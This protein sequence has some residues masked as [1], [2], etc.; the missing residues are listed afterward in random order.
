MQSGADERG[1]E[2]PDAEADADAG[3]D[4]PRT[5]HRGGGAAG[6]ARAAARR[7]A[8]MCIVTRERDPAR[9]LIRFVADPDGRVVPDLAGKLPGRGAHVTASAALVRRAVDRHMFRRALKA[10]VTE[11]R[12]LDDET[13][14]LMRDQLV[15]TLPLLR[16]G[17]ALTVGAGKVEDAVRAGRVILVLHAAEAAED[18]VRKIAQAR[19]ATRHAHG[20]DIPVDRMFTADELGLAFGGSRVIHAAIRPGGGGEAFMAALRRYRSYCG[21]TSEDE[22]AAAEVAG[23]SRSGA[24]GVEGPDDGSVRKGREGEIGARGGAPERMGGQGSPE[25]RAAEGAAGASSTTR[26]DGP[27]RTT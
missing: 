11:P 17:G 1:A 2:A 20:V 9:G 15:A 27:K 7:N 18:G 8:R 3:A 6:N 24:D 23:P 13:A 16:K 12:D 22:G 4:A 10:D 19:T 5:G 21:D 26:D 25:G 14:R